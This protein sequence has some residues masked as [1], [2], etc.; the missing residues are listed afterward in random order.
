MD[1]TEGVSHGGHGGHGGD[2]KVLIA[3][4]GLWMRVV[5]GRAVE[6]RKS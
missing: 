5:V 3:G 1:E 2:G 6:A 4:I